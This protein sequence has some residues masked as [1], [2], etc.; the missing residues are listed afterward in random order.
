MGIVKYM[1]FQVMIK[2]SEITKGVNINGKDPRLRFGILKSI[3]KR[4]KRN[5]NEIG[6]KAKECSCS[7]SQM[8][9][10]YKDERVIN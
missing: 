6:G 5:T 3:E 7:G 4:L 1:V 2:L 8:K 9:K 10:V